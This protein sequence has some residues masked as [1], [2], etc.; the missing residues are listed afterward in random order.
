L[1]ARP[2]PVSLWSS[3]FATFG[4]VDHFVQ[5]SPGL[6]APC[7]G[8]ALVAGAALWIGIGSTV[9]LLLTQGFLIEALSKFGSHAG[10]A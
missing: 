3:S 8:L 2:P 4:H 1:S 9:L 10:A 5:P 6:L 7:L